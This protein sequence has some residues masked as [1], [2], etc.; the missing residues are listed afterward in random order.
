MHSG[1]NP[2]NYFSNFSRFLGF[3]FCSL[4]EFDTRKKS[5]NRRLELLYV[6]IIIKFKVSLTL[7][8]N[9][10]PKSKTEY[11]LLR[12]ISLFKLN[13]VFP[14]YTKEFHSWLFWS[15]NNNMP[16]AMHTQ[17]LTTLQQRCERVV[18]GR[19]KLPELQEVEHRLTKKQTKLTKN[20]LKKI[21]T[22]IKKIVR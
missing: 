18:F 22:N 1:G 17:M 2:Q 3:S 4:V 15:T 11:K 12:K 16:L 9:I 10:V 7:F 19:Q 20:V 13:L 6:H 14:S 5:I 21:F 8:K